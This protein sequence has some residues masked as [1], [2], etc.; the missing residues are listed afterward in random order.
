MPNDI[1]YD[2]FECIQLKLDFTKEKYSSEYRNA[3]V[4]RCCNQAFIHQERYAR[5]QARILKHIWLAD[6]MK[7]SIYPINLLLGIVKKFM[8]IL[9]CQC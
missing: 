2:V 6:Y 5:L 9:L 4:V 3:W 7:Y 8:M 1:S